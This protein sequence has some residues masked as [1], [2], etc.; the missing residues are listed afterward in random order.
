MTTTVLSVEPGAARI[1]RDRD[2]WDIDHRPALL[3]GFDGAWELTSGGRH[4]RWFDRLA[5]A[6]TWLRGPD[7]QAWLD[8][9]PK[10]D[11]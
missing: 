9:L 1:R 3:Q 2:R 4:V 5:D 11:S 8:S 6:R 7:G 10:A